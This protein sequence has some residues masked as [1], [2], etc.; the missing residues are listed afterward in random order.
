MPF[1]IHQMLRSWYGFNRSFSVLI[2][3]FCHWKPFSRLRVNGFHLAITGP[4][5]IT[6]QPHYICST[7]LP[8]INKLQISNQH[9][10][11]LGVII[12]YSAGTDGHASVETNIPVDHHGWISSILCFPRP[13]DLNNPRGLWILEE[14]GLRGDVRRGFHKNEITPPFWKINVNTARSDFRN[15][16]RKVIPKRKRACW[17]GGKAGWKCIQRSLSGCCSSATIFKMSKL[18]NKAP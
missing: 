6:H 3:C 15:I 17:V 13:H 8:R 18:K 1:S 12:W 5:A 4:R 9:E 16:C 11:S 2:F 14:E 10:A 7:S